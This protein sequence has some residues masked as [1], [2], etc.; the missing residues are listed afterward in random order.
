MDPQTKRDVRRCV[1]A[2]MPTVPV[3]V[4]DFALAQASVFASA[5]VSAKAAAGGCNTAAAKRQLFVHRSMN[6]GDFG[7]YSL[8]VPR[9]KAA[10]RKS[11]AFGNAQ[12]MTFEMA[13]G[14][15]RGRRN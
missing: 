2:F 9:G 3:P 7:E 8:D 13:T 12:Q 15:K 6:S 5:T 1:Q 14:H 11:L 4:V 10:R